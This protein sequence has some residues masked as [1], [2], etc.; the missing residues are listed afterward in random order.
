MKYYICIYIEQFT[1]C[2]LLFGLESF[3]EN[4]RCA[5]LITRNPSIWHFFE[6]S[7]KKKMTSTLKRKSF[8]EQR[9]PEGG[10]NALYFF[11][12]SLSL[13]ISGAATRKR[14]DYFAA[15]SVSL[16]FV[17]YWTSAQHG[18]PLWTKS[19]SQGQRH[20]RHHHHRHH[21]QPSFARINECATQKP[22][23]KVNSNVH[24]PVLMYKKIPE[25]NN[26]NI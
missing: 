1:I 19:V 2:S 15:T 10:R 24:P 7:Y 17:L 12:S 5:S 13:R 9:W 26:K 16:A 25:K 18:S 14:A 22:N 6:I 20:H 11:Y 3:W 21:H 8:G 23:S 4:G